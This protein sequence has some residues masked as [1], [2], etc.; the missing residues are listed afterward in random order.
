[1][2]KYV[3]F[4]LIFVKILRGV[5]AQSTTN[6]ISVDMPQNHHSKANWEL[7]FQDEF[8]GDSL[9][10]SLWWLQEELH[11]DKMVYYRNH[12]DNYFLKDGNLTIRAV[13]DSFKNAPY[14]SALLFSSKS[15]E[16][17]TLAEIRCKIPKGKGLWPA[18][19][20]WKGAWD[21]TYQELDAFEFWCENT[22]QFCVSNHY[23]DKKKKT[24]STHF[25]WIRP[26]TTDGRAIDMSKQFFTYSVYWDDAGVKILLNN[27]LVTVIKQNIPTQSFPLIINL[28][29]DGGKGKQPNK[30]TI[31]PA[32]FII[33]YVRVYKRLNAT[34]SN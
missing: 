33:D 22:E 7:I 29:V 32:D 25:R 14:T 8:E 20:F 6:I 10:T 18:F 12:K 23:W 5:S 30:N 26:R 11:V 1:M 21:S 34:P 31:F 17:G 2:K 28:C 3:L 16:K 19:W 24:V 27:K 9:N 15:F 13:Q 4:I